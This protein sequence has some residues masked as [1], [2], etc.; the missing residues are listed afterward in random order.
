M[1]L[2]FNDTNLVTKKVKELVKAVQKESCDAKLFN[3]LSEIMKVIGQDDK[4][5]EKYKDLYMEAEDELMMAGA[6][7]EKCGCDP[8]KRQIPRDKV[9]Y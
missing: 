7:L 5:F 2:D 4:L 8:L 6:D 3:E 9:Q 1:G